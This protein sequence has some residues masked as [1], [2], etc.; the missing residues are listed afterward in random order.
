MA[1]FTVLGAT[2]FIGSRLANY[3]EQRGDRVTRPRFGDAVA[4]TDLGHVIYCIGLTADFR[5]R[6]F[7]TMDAHVNLLG[8]FLK[9]TRFLSFL[10]L[11]STRVYGRASSTEETAKIPIDPSAPGDLY[12][13]SKLAGEALCLSHDDPAIR[14][15]RLSNV[16]GGGGGGIGGGIAMAP[17]TFLASIIQSAVSEDHIPLRTALGSC[18]DYIAADDVVAAL[19][20]I[21][22]RGDNRLYN[23]AAG[24]NTSNR[25]ITG[26]LCRI[27]GCS[28][29]V[30]PGAP[31]ADFPAID[32]TRL[33]ADFAAAGKSWDPAPVI[34]RLED[35]VS[36][37]RPESRR[38]AGGIK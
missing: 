20:V 27:T 2:G 14:V 13:I 22:L 36:Y 4:A 33:R 30:E 21:A 29:S 6:P 17:D 8:E 3:L 34:E 37:Y 38:L 16:F 19:R 11:S 25:D 35:L 28:M 7:D 18:K 26:E 10:Y 24:A 23:V 12:N 31:T 9:N 5:S 32:T 1:R 15:A